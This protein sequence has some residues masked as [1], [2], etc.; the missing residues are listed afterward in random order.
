MEARLCW[1][2]AVL[3]LPPLRAGAQETGEGQ[4]TFVR[5]CAKCH[6]PDGVPRRIAKGAP[7]FTDPAWALP[8]YLIE[9]SVDEGKGK[10]MP[11]FRGKLSPEEIK[12]VV[13][14]VL[15][16]NDLT[17]GSS[18]KSAEPSVKQPR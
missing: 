11:R 18:G 4:A 6:G 3:A 12:K 7:N 8:V 17:A 10:D 15:S 5:K 9:H 13:T 1:L 2:L 16:L 14:Y